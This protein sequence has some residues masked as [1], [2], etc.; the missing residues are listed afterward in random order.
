MTDYLHIAPK[1]RDV[2]FKSDDE[3]ILFLDSPRWIHYRAGAAL[4]D[5]LDGLLRKPTRPRMPNLFAVGAS[6]SGKTTILHRFMDS[7]GQSYISDDAT[8]VRPVICVEIH[9]PDERELYNAILSEFWAPHNPTA[10][11]SKLRHQAMHMMREARVRM[12]IVD[13][14]HTINNGSPAKRMDTMNE[15]KMLGNVMSIS[16]VLVGTRTALQLLVLD[17]QYASRFKVV[18]LPAWSANAEFQGF[19]KSFESVLPLKNPSKIYSPELATLIHA[20]SDGN[21]GNVEYL[22][23]EC[24]KEAIRNGSEVIDRKL[25]EKNRCM[26]PTSTNGLQEQ[27]L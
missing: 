24:A 26:R 8:S 10:P 27:V 13:E 4:L 19:L 25:L 2:M 21:T 22:L 17:A 3:R 5:I 14:A 18:S 7:S 11:L 23:R 6:N 20:I 1:F 12:L 16:L 9:K 15:L